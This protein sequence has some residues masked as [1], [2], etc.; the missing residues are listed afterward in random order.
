MSEAASTSKDVYKRQALISA[1]PTP[2]ATKGDK[3]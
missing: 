3:P 2:K 1:W